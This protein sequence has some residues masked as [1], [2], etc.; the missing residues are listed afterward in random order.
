MDEPAFAGCLIPSK[1][2]G[3]IQANQTER[4][5]KVARNDRLI[6]VASE[7]KSHKQVKNLN[8]LSESVIGEIKHFFISYNEAK[9]KEFEPI[10]QFGATCAKNIVEEGVKKHAAKQR[11][12]K[13]RAVK[14]K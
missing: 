8:D 4:D 7:S 6:A 5:G 9:G 2:I 10:G 11:E 14:K 3:V 1:L 13:S 12:K